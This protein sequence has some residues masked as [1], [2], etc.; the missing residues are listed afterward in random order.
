LNSSP[1]EHIELDIDIPYISSNSKRC[2]IPMN[3]DVYSPPCITLPNFDTSLPSIN[4]LTSRNVLMLQLSPSRSDEIRILQINTNITIIRERATNTEFNVNSNVLIS[5]E[6]RTMHTEAISEEE[7]NIESIE[8]ESLLDYV[9]E[10]RDIYHSH[11]ISSIKPDRFV[12]IYV[13]EQLGKDWESPLMRIMA[14]ICTLIAEVMIGHSEQPKDYTVH[15]DNEGFIIRSILRERVYPGIILVVRS[16]KELPDYLARDILRE[17]DR[18]RSLGF[19]V[20]NR[21]AIPKEVW[22]SEVEI[23]PCHRIDI[24]V[25]PRLDYEKLKKSLC[26]IAAALSGFSIHEDDILQRIGENALA[27]EKA[28]SMSIGTFRKLIEDIN[29]E[30]E[31]AILN[32]PSTSGEESALHRFLKGLVIWWLIKRYFNENFDHARSKI[33]V[34]E[35]LSC[36]I[37]DIYAELPDGRR[38]IVEVKTL[39]NKGVNPIWDELYHNDQ[40]RRYARYADEV[41]IL[42]PPWI[43]IL[44]TRALLDVQKTYL[45]DNMLSNV[46]IV[47]IYFKSKDNV[48]IIPVT[49]YIKL[50]KNRLRESIK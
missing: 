18:A 36:G 37:P 39:F 25:K 3:V 35:Q 42:V 19:L 49:N 45:K 23:Q 8:C 30:T 27:F 50:V 20:I 28:V 24:V 44:F 9:L 11:G 32:K 43:P 38:L 40:I 21:S 34:E 46:K 6:H 16:S 29:N 48:N 14:D 1:I 41:W 22:N 10:F 47:T 15:E 13:L 4:N 7:K 33:H 2:F 5:S 26:L 31:V 17:I 12:V